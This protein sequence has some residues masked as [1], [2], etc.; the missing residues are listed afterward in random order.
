[1]KQYIGLD[2]SMKET[3]ITLGREWACLC[4]LPMESGNETS[5]QGGFRATC[6]ST[7]GI[8]IRTS[9]VD[10]GYVL[11]PLLWTGRTRNSLD[12]RPFP[13]DEASRPPGH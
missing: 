9:L 6:E 2:V 1:M 10:E 8:T 7:C 12:M 5:A 3:A 4:Y 11:I 13:E